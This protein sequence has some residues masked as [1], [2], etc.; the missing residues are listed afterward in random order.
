M[1]RDI[2]LVADHPKGGRFPDTEA[3]L[4]ARLDSDAQFILER[5]P[6]ASNEF[7]RLVANTSGVPRDG[8]AAQLYVRLVELRAALA[9]PDTPAWRA[10]RAGIAYQNLVMIYRHPKDASARSGIIGAGGVKAQKALAQAMQAYLADWLRQ[11]GLHAADLRVTGRDAAARKRLT[12]AR[13]AFDAR[14]KSLATPARFRAAREKLEQS[15]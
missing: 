13:D 3:G 8:I 4:L 14:F 5:H 11:R 9:D 6:C 2:F 15:K 7:W 10:A 12:D 1:K